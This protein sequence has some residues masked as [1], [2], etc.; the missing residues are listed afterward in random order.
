MKTL[1]TG[2]AR[3]KAAR[4]RR[5][6]DPLRGPR[7]GSRRVPGFTLLELLV[8]IV[9][10]AILVGLL[11]VVVRGARRVADATACRNNVRQY[12]LALRMYN[13]DFDG[14][15]PPYT[16]SNVEG[17][18]AVQWQAR[19]QAYL[20]AGQDYT[21]TTTL[22]I[23]TANR[24][25]PTTVDVCPSF[26]RL[27]GG[28]Y[29]RLPGGFGF[30]SG[31]GDYWDVRTWSRLGYLTYA[32]NNE[33][34]SKV[35]VPGTGRALGG[36]ALVPSMDGVPPLQPP[37]PNETRPVRESEVMAPSDLIAVGDAQ[38]AGGSTGV[39]RFMGIDFL[40]PGE[41]GFNPYCQM[42]DSV[43][44]GGGL[45]GMPAEVR[46]GVAAGVAVVRQRHDGRWNVSFC[47]GHV[48]NLST[49][50]LFDPAGPDSALRR[51][52]RDNL[53]H[54]GEITMPAW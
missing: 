42:M 12:A 9:I 10:I 51:W 47:D 32:Y 22:E 19:L 13:D 26:W 45:S 7:G 15:Y 49:K 24:A 37:G 21:F 34:V 18:Q 46:A 16:M 52:N 3:P 44:G 40:T 35:V 8:V 31:A 53:P 30:G 28:G 5:A 50:D 54:R 17:E 39:W 43:T 38:I 1:R 20:H 36:V 48:E 2:T 33:G 4:V 25:V 27:G 6:G 11:L 29:D 41:L 23:P 14:A